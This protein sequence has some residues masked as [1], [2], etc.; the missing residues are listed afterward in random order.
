VIL[1]EQAWQLA[2][3][4]YHDRLAPDFRRKSV[5]EAQQLF[6]EIGLTSQFWQLPI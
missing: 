4:W 1:L 2:R 3:G 5:S 6:A